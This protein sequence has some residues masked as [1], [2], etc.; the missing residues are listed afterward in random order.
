MAGVYSVTVT[1]AN[2]CTVSL[3]TNVVVNALPNAMAS[4]NSPVCVDQSINLTASGGTNYSWSGPG[5]FTSTLQNPTR[6]NA[7]AAMAGTYTVTVTDGNG[8]SATA[9]TNVTVTV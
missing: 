6:T 7:T 9:T 8:C 5:G 1:N 3:T 4:S 2:G